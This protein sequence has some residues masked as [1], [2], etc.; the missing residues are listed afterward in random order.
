MAIKM[1]DYQIFKC[2]HCACEFYD[3]S[4]RNGMKIGN[5]MMN[6]PQCKKPIYVD[7]TLEPAMISG[8][9]CFDIKF[10]SLYG[11][12]RIGMILIFSLFL[13]II[14]VTRSFT[15]ALGFIAAG[16]VIYM[17]YH[18]ARVVH[19]GNYLSSSE[20]DEEINS[21]LERLES[22]A[23]ATMIGN[24]QGTDEESVYF[25]KI[26]QKDEENCER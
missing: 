7:S 17:L 12:L 4:A 8:K 21:S 3:V 5:P 10:S 9:R 20:Y 19:R 1:K 22:K 15:L 13:F 2:P 6:C 26:N 14:L 24:A 25:Y 18:V 11:N 16:A 23:Y